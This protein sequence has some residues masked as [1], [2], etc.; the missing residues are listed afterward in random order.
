MMQSF[1]DRIENT[2]GKSE[3]AGY[4]HILLFPTMFSEVFIDSINESRYYV[5]M[6]YSGNQV[7]VHMFTVAW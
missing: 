3:N 7:L 1:F 4:Q 2:V 5:A 6:G